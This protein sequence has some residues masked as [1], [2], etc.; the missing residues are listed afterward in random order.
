MKKSVLIS[1]RIFDIFF[2]LIGTIILSPFLII[3]S[4]LIKLTS[5]GPVLFKQTRVGLN[6]K[7]F[8]ILKFRTMIPDAEKKGLKITVGED[9]RITGIGKFLRKYKLDE[10]PQIINVLKGDMSV[11]GPRPEVRKYVDHYTKEQMQVLTARPGVTD[12]ASVKYKNENEVL[13]RS[14]NPEETYINEVM[15]EKLRINLDYITHANIIYDLKLILLTV[16]EVFF[17]KS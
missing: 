6:N 15:Q 7:D 2:G 5:E 11:V 9:P 3:I 14:S 12:L 8:K 1:K 4:I 17:D 10:L 13:G 16:K